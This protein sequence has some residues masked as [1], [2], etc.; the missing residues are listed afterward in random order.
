MHFLS[1]IVP[2]VALIG[3]VSSH[4]GEHEEHG[5]LARREFLGFAERSIAGCQSH[6]AARGHEQKSIARRAALAENLRRKRGLPV[7]AI[8]SRFWTP[9]Q[10]EYDWP[11]CRV[12]RGRNLHWNT[13]LC[14]PA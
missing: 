12:H 4:P 1:A 7:N 2:I 14:P 8:W 3:S 9:A 11:H 5:T 10:V 6:L 13:Q